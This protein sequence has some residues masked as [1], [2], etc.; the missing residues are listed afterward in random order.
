L[1]LPANKRLT[2]PK[3]LPGHAGN[4]FD[5][6]LHTFAKIEK[7]PV[8][9]FAL[10]LLILALLPRLTHPLTMLVLWAFM[11]GDWLLLWLLPKAGKSFGPSKP[12]VLLLSVMRALLG[13]LPLPY[14]LAIQSVGT[15]LVIH[16]FWIEPFRLFLTRQTLASPKWRETHPLR[17]LH[18]GDLHVE[19]ISDRERQLTGTINAIKPDL[20][21]FSGDILN[22]SYL[23]D[24]LAWEDARTVLGSWEAPLG[25]FGVMGSPAVDLPDIFPE[26]VKGLKIRWLF[27]EKV[28]VIVGQTTLD[29]IGISCTHNPQQDIETLKTC[30]PDGNH[31]TILLYH[32]P[33]LAP[34]ANQV[35]I[36]LQLSGHTHGGQVRLPVIGALITA[37]INGKRFE[38]GHYKLNGL[39]LYV[40]RGIGME[41]AGAPRVR[42]LCPPEIILWEIQT[43]TS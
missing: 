7:V 19:R 38:A 6:F 28:S 33:D 34:L 8:L 12:P 22:L 24:P 43:T 3:P 41:G 37:E 23:K 25:V 18:L 10:V 1:H 17:I 30:Q 21:L 11:L 39:T 40:T 35:G 14:L 15:I 27:D 16:G 4:P 2:K 13:W 9:L 20:I 36:D 29:I 5:V 42:F 26:L 32:T 31:L